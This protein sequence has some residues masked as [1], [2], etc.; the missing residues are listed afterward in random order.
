MW[1][2]F[3]SKACRPSKSLHPLL[4]AGVILD[5]E[6]MIKPSHI[7]DEDYRHAQKVFE[8]FSCENLANYTRLY[9][10]LD[11]LLLADVFESF[12]DVCLG[13]YRLDP[14]HYITASSLSWDAMLKM[15]DVKLELLTD[16]DM[17]LFFEEGICGGVS[18]I[19]NSYVKAN[20]KYMKGYNPE[21]SA[22]IQY[23]DANNLYGWAMSQHLPVGNFQWLDKS[24]IYTFT[25]YP[26]WIRSCTL[27]V[28]LEY[29][30]GYTTSTATTRWPLRT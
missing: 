3:E 18:T 16:S 30:K 24:E 23:L 1:R 4:G 20:H 17:H 7:S 28:D 2:D 13:K 27:E 14:S 12:I 9:C 29:P 10:K 25:K 8:A 22:Y 15:T 26:E 19:T 21:E 5:S 6:A 11:V